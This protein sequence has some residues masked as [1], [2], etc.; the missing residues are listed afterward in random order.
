MVAF[1]LDERPL[2]RSVTPLDLCAPGALEHALDRLDTLVVKPRDGYGGDGVVVCAH[3]GAAARDKA[4]RAI[5]RHPE[6]FVVQPT[7]MLSHHPT[8]V[9]TELAPRH[10]DLR[11]FVF[12]AGDR[13][14]AIPGG[15]TRFARDAGALVVNSSRG[16]GGKDTWVLA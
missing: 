13:V 14:T 8:V 12:T 2:L 3:A 15:L 16:G 11:P 1:Y 5:V 6:R 9:G 4:A 7:V 10:V